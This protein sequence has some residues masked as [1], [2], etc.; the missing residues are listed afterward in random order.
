LELPEK[1]DFVEMVFLET[2][3]LDEAEVSVA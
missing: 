3:E 1:V 2:E